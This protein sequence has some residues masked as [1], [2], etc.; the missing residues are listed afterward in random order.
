[1]IEAWLDNQ[2]WQAAIVLVYLVINLVGGDA[3]LL[4]V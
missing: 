1:M 3:G 2:Q 4:A